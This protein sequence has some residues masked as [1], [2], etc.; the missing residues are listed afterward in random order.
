MSTTLDHI[1]LWASANLRYWEQA[2]LQKILDGSTV[3]DHDHRELVGYFEQDAGLA[4]TPSDRPRLL[5]VPETP[6]EATG[7]TVRLGRIFNVRNVNALEE[8]HELL[9]GNQLTVIYGSNGAGKT[10][11]AR[12]LGSACFARG[13]RD[14]L[15]DATRPAS[16][17]RPQADIEISCG[18]V[19]ATI[20]WEAG[21]PAPAELRGFHVFDDE[22]V[23]IHLAQAN[24]LSFSP[25]G[26]SSLTNLASLTDSVRQSVRAMIAE[27]EQPHSIGDFFPGDSGIKSL[28]AGVRS[29]ADVD[30]LEEKAAFSPTDRERRTQMEKQ[31]ATLRLLNVPKRIAKL[32]QEVRDIEG[33]RDSLI[34]SRD[35]LGTVCEA[36]VEAILLRVQARRDEVVKS[37]VSQF[38]SDRFTQVGSPEWVA[39][40]SAAKTL[41]TAERPGSLPYPEEGDSCLLCRQS[42]SPESVRL[43]HSLWAFLTSNPQARLEEAE[44]AATSKVIAL[45]AINFSYFAPDASGRRLIEHD[46]PTLAPSIEAYI[47]ACAARRT[48]LIESLTSQK[49]RPIPPVTTLSIGELDVLVYNRRREIEGLQK[50]DVGQQLSDAESSL[51]DLEHRQLLAE[52]IPALRS[53]VQRTMWAAR[54]RECL[55]STRTITTKH[56]DLFD[57]LVKRRY[58]ELFESTL[59]RFNGNMQVMVDTRGQKGVTVRQ[60]VLNPKRYLQNQPISKVLS[61]GEKHA[62]AVADFLAEAALDGNNNG[63]ILDDPVTSLDAAWKSTLAESL[64]EHASVRQVVVFTHDLTFV[65]RLKEFSESL[66]VDVAAHWV[67][68]EN[69]KPGFVYSNNSPASERQYKS[70]SVAREY[71]AKAKDMQPSEQQGILQLGF[72]ALRTSY[73]VLIITGVFNDVVCRFDERISFGR[74][75]EVRVDPVLVEDIICRMEALS[76][77]IEG[78][79]HS[80]VYAET[81]PTRDDLFAEIE[82]FEWIKSRQNALRKADP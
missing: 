77:F 1:R 81:K 62:V 40:L 16:T 71:Y 80:D 63:I 56:D 60:I 19:Q 49:A 46:L 18:G 36:D 6:V 45:E 30:T 9:F 79:S 29:S 35:E 75:R 42:L 2:A 47:E 74:L 33:V 14:V 22:S 3:S 15:P 38:M 50:S 8:G 5:Q 17:V 21:L 26:L 28:I 10:G 66:G 61:D 4:T 24:R 48:E 52:H 12:P 54:A 65:Y 51:R 27:R 25:A 73:E 7:S 11:Y 34:R 72:A 59:A 64:V 32:Q 41:A 31:V 68:C 78:H 76:R 69:G 43:L 70:A 55:G 39:F 23:R 13:E 82:A 53:F 58:K 67:R 44:K 57:A 20:H 37:G